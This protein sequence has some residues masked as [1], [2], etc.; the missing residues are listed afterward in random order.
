LNSRTGI[1]TMQT[2]KNAKRVVKGNKKGTEPR[3]CDSV[4]A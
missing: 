2:T 3:P 4:F 1:E